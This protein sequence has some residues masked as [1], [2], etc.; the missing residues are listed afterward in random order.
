[1][2]RPSD[3]LRFGDRLSLRAVAADAPGGTGI[4]HVELFADAKRVVKVAGPV[5]R[6]DPWFGARDR[7]G[8]G[9]H[10]LTFVARDG[11]GNTA[12]RVVRVEKVLA[13]LLPR[14]TP[15]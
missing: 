4:S 10:T 11:A 5:L 13:S 1:M 9:A 2:V 3:G 6:L 12:Q 15:G 7:L 8:L 14:C